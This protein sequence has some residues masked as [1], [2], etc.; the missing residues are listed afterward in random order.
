[1]TTLACAMQI[2]D[3]YIRTSIYM[4]IST[5][6]YRLRHSMVQLIQFD[7]VHSEKIRLLERIVIMIE[8]VCSRPVATF[9]VDN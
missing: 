1:M 6:P 7:A 8:R 2:Q 5:K 9:S 4:C 3:V